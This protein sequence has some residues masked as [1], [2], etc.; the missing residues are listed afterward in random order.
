MANVNRCDRQS[1]APARGLQTAKRL[2]ALLL[3]QEN[4]TLKSAADRRVVGS[5]PPQL[6]GLTLEICERAGRDTSIAS[7]CTMAP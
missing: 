6:T 3:S 5:H 2:K 1:R 7:N 4:G